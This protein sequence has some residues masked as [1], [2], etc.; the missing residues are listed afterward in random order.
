MYRKS[1]LF[2]A[3]TSALRRSHDRLEVASLRIFERMRIIQGA[4]Q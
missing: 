4:C 3:P 1:G 2:D